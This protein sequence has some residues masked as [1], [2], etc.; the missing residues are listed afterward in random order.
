MNGFLLLALAAT[1]LLPLAAAQPPPPNPPH[2]GT[3]DQVAAGTE[4][5]LNSDCSI[6][7]WIGGTSGCHVLRE[8]AVRP[9]AQGFVVV[10]VHVCDPLV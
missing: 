8:Q 3:R 1:L 10:R 9:T 2:C 4:T 6:D 7:A 5:R